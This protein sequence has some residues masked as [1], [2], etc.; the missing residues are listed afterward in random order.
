MSK[1]LQ[2]EKGLSRSVL[3]AC[4]LFSVLFWRWL[5]NIMKG[6]TAVQ[7]CHCFVFNKQSNSVSSVLLLLNCNL[8]NREQ[9]TDSNQ[10]YHTTSTGFLSSWLFSRVCVCVCLCVPS[11]LTSQSLTTFRYALYPI[12]CQPREQGPRPGCAA[13]QMQGDWDWVRPWL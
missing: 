8:T 6:N 11:V 4:L 12:L 10:H 7:K 1:V 3:L 13:L 9:L 2:C 5:P